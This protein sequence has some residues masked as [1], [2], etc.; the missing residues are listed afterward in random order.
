MFTFIF[1][2]YKEQHIGLNSMELKVHGKGCKKS[3]LEGLFF[4]RF[5]ASAWGSINLQDR[6][7]V[8]ELEELVHQCTSCCGCT[9]CIRD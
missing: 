7:Q 4:G 8:K 5:K 9:L 3:K 1:C 6:S 2:A